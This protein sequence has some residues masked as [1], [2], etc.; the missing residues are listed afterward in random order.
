MSTPPG[1]QLARTT[2]TVVVRG[3]ALAGWVGPD[4][5]AS[6]LYRS[7]GTA[8]DP[9]EDPRLA[10][11]LADRA[12][13]TV[14][15]EH[16]DRSRTEH[17]NGWTAHG[18][19]AS[20]QVHKVY[21]SPT[22]PCLPAALPVVFAT[23]VALDVPSWKVGADAA[24]L[25]RPDKI[26]LYLPSAQRADAVAAALADA[27]DGLEAQGVPFTGQVGATAMVSR[28]RDHGRTSWRAVL[29][30][31]VARALCDERAARG[32]DAPAAEVADAA[33][34][35]LART[36]DVAGWSPELRARVPA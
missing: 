22:L 24:G 30:R 13:R 4:E 11:H 17:W 6:V 34:G 16:H 36:Y 2:R 32:P 28:G 19:D 27:L 15:L 3:A 33:L 35:R 10:R 21:I 12:E 23:A 5:L 8:V 14:P 18:T 1:G 29:C 20:A 7:G 26:V 31:A 9:R 25:H